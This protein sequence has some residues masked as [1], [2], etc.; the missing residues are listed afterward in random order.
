MMKKIITCVCVLGLA[1]GGPVS[2]AEDRFSPWMYYS[3]RTNLGTKVCG[4]SSGIMN[5]NIGQNLVIKALDNNPPRIVVDLYKDTWNYSEGES[6]TVMLDFGDNQPV[7]FDGYGFGHIMEIT[8]PMNGLSLFL[9]KVTDRPFMQVIFPD[10]QD[11]TWT[12][13]YTGSTNAVRRLTA[14]AMRF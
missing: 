11:G 7:N 2:A 12:V 5:A 13:A 4:M 8:I 10:G 6:R 14:C 9:G 3:G 1:L